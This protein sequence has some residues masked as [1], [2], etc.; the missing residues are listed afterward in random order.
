MAGQTNYVEE[1]AE[2]NMREA[3]NFTVHFFAEKDVRRVL[4]GGTDDNIA[5]FRTLLPKALQ[6]LVVGTFAMSMTMSHADVMQKV[7]H[8]VQTR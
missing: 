2:R 1:V 6:S 3:A 4:I 7:L 5:H 8:L